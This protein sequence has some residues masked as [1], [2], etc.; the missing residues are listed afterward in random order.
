MFWTGFTKIVELRGT[1]EDMVSG[2]SMRVLCV[3]VR[4][5]NRAAD[6]PDEQ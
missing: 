6:W 5:T 2:L 1:R 4:W 3:L